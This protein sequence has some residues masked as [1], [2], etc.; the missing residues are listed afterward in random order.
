LPGDW[1]GRLAP[2]FEFVFHFRRAPTDGKELRPNKTKAKQAAS[3]K[4]RHLSHDMR[5]KS[6]KHGKHSSPAAHQQPNKIPDSIIRAPRHKVQL[7]GSA[8]DH[9]AAFSVQFASEVITAFTQPGGTVYEPFSGSGTTILAC[10][11][12]GRTALA[13]EIAP[14]YA[15]VSVRRWQGFTGRTG[16]CVA[17]STLAAEASDA[18]AAA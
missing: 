17:A 5:A 12:H 4:V 14:A 11:I 8:G 7:G 1:K 6:G 3:I 15:D 9:P 10:E 13:M 2:A 16:R 18:E